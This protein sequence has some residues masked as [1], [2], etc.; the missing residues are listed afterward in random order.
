MEKIVVLVVDREDIET[1]T[2]EDPGIGT[3]DHL[4]VQGV[5]VMEDE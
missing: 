1:D 5:G 3:I 2:I 4:E